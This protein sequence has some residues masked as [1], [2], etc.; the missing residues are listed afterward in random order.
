MKIALWLLT[1]SAPAFA[2]A[3]KTPVH[4]QC[5]CDDAVGARY[6]TAVR[7]LIAKSPRYIAVPDFIVGDT[8]DGHWNYGIRVIS[9]DPST[10]NI[11]N[12][13]AIAIVITFGPLFDNTQIQTCYASDIQT[14]ADNTMAFFDKT[15]ESFK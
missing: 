4:F 10:N 7:D 5:Q 1:L 15:V 14:C 13:S 3:S 11:G 9:L 6:A 8:K 2:Q 12:M